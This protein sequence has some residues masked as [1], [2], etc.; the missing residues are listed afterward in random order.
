MKP[1]MLSKFKSFLKKNIKTALVAGAV[2]LGTIV[3]AQNYDI[4]FNVRKLQHGQGPYVSG[5]KIDIDNGSYMGFTNANGVVNIPDVPSGNH[6]IRVSKEGYLQY[7][8][9]DY[10][11]NSNSTFDACILPKTQIGPWGTNEFD[12][13]KY[14]ATFIISTGGY[15]GNRDPPQWAQIAP[16]E[17]RINVIY[18]PN[19]NPH[20]DSLLIQEAVS[21]LESMTG[22]DLITIGVYPEESS[23]TININDNTNFSAIGTDVDGTI[24][25]GFSQ[26]TQ[27]TQK[28]R[29]IHEIVKQFDMWPLSTYIYPSVMDP[30]VFTMTDLQPWDANHIAV[31]FDQHYA[32]LRNEQ[33][34]FISNME[35]RTIPVTPNPTVITSPQNNATNLSTAVNTVWNNISG[36]DK[37][38]M[39]IATDANFTNII[40][41][42][43]VLRKDTTINL[44][45][46]T[47]YHMRVRTE[48]TAGNSAWSQAVTFTTINNTP[49][50]TNITTPANNA[51][52]VPT[53]TTFNWTQSTNATQY[54]LEVALN[55]TF[56]NPEFDITA[57]G[58]TTNVNLTG[59]RTYFSRVR[60]E[61]VNGNGQWSQTITFQTLNHA[62]SA[63]TNLTPTPSNPQNA[64]EPI[65]FTWTQSTD[66]DNDPI[67]YNL[68]IFNG[69]FNQTYQNIVTNTTTIP[70]NTLQPGSQYTYNVTANDGELNTQSLDQIL[71]TIALTIGSNSITSPAN[72]AT[73]VPTTTSY[74]WTQ[75]NNAERY[76]LEVSLNNT[77][78]NI[79]QDVIVYDL[80][81]ILNLN[82]HRTY[83]NRIRGENINGTNVG[84]WSSTTTF[85]TINTA[86]T[87]PTNL[88][89]T[90][91]NPQNAQE[92]IIFTWTQST[93]IDN[94]PITYNLHIF[95]GTFNEI[96]NNITTNNYTLQ[97]NTLQPNSQYTY[98]ITAN[99]GELN[100]QSIDEII[101]TVA[102]TIGNTNITSPANNAT[103]VPRDAQYTWTQA[104][105]ATKY[106]LEVSLNNTF[107]NMIK[108]VIVY[109]LDTILNLNG[110][111]TYF[112]R[113]RGETETDAGPWSQVTT[114]T[115]INTLPETPIITSPDT[116]IA[117][118]ED[119]Q[120][121]Q[122]I[123]NYTTTA[124]DFDNDQVTTT[125]NVTGPNVNET[126]ITTQG[127][128]IT[129][130]IDSLLFEPNEEYTATIRA[131][132]N[133]GIVNG[134]DVTFIALVVGTNN[135]DRYATFSIY[136]NPTDGSINIELPV[137]LNTG[138][139]LSVFNSHGQEV[140]GLIVE[141]YNNQGPRIDLST[142]VE[143]FYILR[144][145]TGKQLFF[146]K[147]LIR[148]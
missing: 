133:T 120:N 84:Q 100:T 60:G 110:N 69:T 142:L 92:P 132:D 7:T 103:N 93:D 33:D 115:T 22:Y 148:K 143:G 97:A 116:W 12:V 6:T 18:R 98:N 9:N 101:N 127:G 105:N 65:I 114:F 55:S 80:D 82:G 40:Y 70:A 19:G 66:I 94:D 119:Y 38:H 8:Q 48:N 42:L 75:A 109:D 26:I 30:D 111:R 49:G 95:N 86:P 108:D 57:T 124:F 104:N 62:P 91:S 102:G 128:Q 106:N 144:F 1:I 73:N 32:K 4:N 21:D 15:F 130:G 112:N 45:P 140:A 5:V 71:N 89:P 126:F 121:G 117:G 99:D 83:F 59:H 29:V 113:V 20:A 27:T 24:V 118:P 123:I 51:S 135:Q 77:F 96:Y 67:T 23:Y 16:I 34:L 81:T 35:E 3:N 13:N 56:T 43:L 88:N 145:R 72:N 11:L 28:K 147:L 63:P 131:T 78:T 61:N 90:A 74:T 64:Q 141:E 2:T 107:T 46:N 36:A 134:E 138:F 41:D 68:H 122:L 10:Q 87:A 37:Y 52:N 139:E 17:N 44:Q 50:N 14:K 53:P 136:P 146:C 39:D 47:Q 25:Y 129:Q 76:N 137:G 85:S 31:T 54:N 58:L 79:V 125:L